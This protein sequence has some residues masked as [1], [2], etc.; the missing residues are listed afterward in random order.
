MIGLGLSLWPVGGKG[1]GG[2]GG[3][4]IILTGQSVLENAA[5]GTLVGT[6]S[7]GGAHTG[8]PVFTL[9]DSA[10]GKFAL[11]VVNS[12]LLEV[13]GALNY[14]TATSHGIVVSVAGTTP[15]APN[16]DFTITIGDVAEGGGVDFSA[17]VNSQVLAALLD[18]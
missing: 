4:Q 8:T 14:E 18:F 11:D 17:A 5:V 12:A 16:R 9:E 15:D 6:L 7:V 1:H 3:P 13:A 10:G 2:G